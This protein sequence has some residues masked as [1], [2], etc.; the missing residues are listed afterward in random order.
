[1]ISSFLIELENIFFYKSE[2]ESF[3]VFLSNLRI[4]FFISLK[5][6]HFK[7]SYRTWEYL[8]LWVWNW[9]I[10]SFL[11]ELENIFFYK[12]ET[13]WFQVFLSNLR[14][15][16]FISL[17]LHHFKFSNRTWRISFSISLKMH[18]FKFSYRTWEY[19]FI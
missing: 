14:I 17:K 12:S 3:Q 1:M 2:T 18:H 8:F 15:S 7:F 5:L 6:N 4:C 13:E 11:I 16:F 10:S 19:L 9:M